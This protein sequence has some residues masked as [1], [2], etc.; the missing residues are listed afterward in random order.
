MKRNWDTVR[1]LLSKVEECT[2]PSDTITLSHFP[3]ERSAE[4]SYHMELLIGA[5]LVDGQM[6]KTMGSGPYQ[7]FARRLTW[8]G[9]E[10][11]DAI[12]SDTVWEKTKKSFVTN[13]ISM[14]FDLIKSVASDV[15]ASLLKATIGS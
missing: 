12:R 11:L 4:I 15:A 7:F 2:L 6:A 13:G 5:G 9:H 10:F 8:Q 3:T 14:T 1:E